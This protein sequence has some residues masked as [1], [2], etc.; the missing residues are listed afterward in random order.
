MRLEEGRLVNM[1]ALGMKVVSLAA[2]APSS[3][4]PPVTAPPGGPVTA[5]HGG[6]CSD[7]CQ[8]P[9]WWR[10]V[11]DARMGALLHSLLPQ[12][13]TPSRSFAQR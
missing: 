13:N 6:L 3:L 1:T 7:H 2:I 12:V 8:V 5:A 4:V 10:R 11:R 9:F